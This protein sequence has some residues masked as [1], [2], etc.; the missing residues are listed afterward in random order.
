V[1]VSAFF[2]LYKY[3]HGPKLRVM[4]VC[5]RDYWYPAGSARLP[6]YTVIFVGLRLC[7]KLSIALAQVSVLVS[8]HEIALTPLMDTIVW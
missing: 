3:L 6:V 8:L 4:I 2:A 7:I 1:K 5:N